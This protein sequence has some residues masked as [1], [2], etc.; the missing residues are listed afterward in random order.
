MQDI[1]FAL[2]V[3]YAYFF[4]GNSLLL[5]KK[6]ILKA[7]NTTL[8]LIKKHLSFSF[9]MYFIMENYFANSPKI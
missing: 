5:L 4:E 2:F 1:V 8:Y 7:H 6:Q 9:E 3:I